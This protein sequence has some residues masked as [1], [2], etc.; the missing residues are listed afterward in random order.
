MRGC[1]FLMDLLFLAVS[2]SRHPHG[3]GGHLA[4]REGKSVRPVLDLLYTQLSIKTQLLPGKHQLWESCFFCKEEK[5]SGSP[6]DRQSQTILHPKPSALPQ[7]PQLS[8]RF[9]KHP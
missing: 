2:Q 1:E 9:W 5:D 8:R 4:I 3:G 7:G 6:K